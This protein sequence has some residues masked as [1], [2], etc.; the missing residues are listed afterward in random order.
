[1][2][3]I[4]LFNDHEGGRTSDKLFHE[5]VVRCFEKVRK[6]G[7]RPKMGT[8]QSWYDHPAE[9]LPEDKEYTFMHLARKIAELN[10]KAK[11][12]KSGVIELYG[13]KNEILRCTVISVGKDYARVTSAR[14][15]RT[16]FVK[17]S[18]LTERSVKLLKQYE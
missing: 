4:F 13:K 7:L 9:E 8:I 3:F 16:G 14:S 18:S 5:G 2:D 12:G 1:M 17:F 6:K 15:G 11:P 10:N